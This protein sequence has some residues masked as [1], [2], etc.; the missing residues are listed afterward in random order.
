MDSSV[1]FSTI[2]TTRSLGKRASDICLSGKS[3][4]NKVAYLFQ[5]SI[6]CD[7]FLPRSP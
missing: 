5:L 3:P 2:T 1:H 4:L 7:A 6:A